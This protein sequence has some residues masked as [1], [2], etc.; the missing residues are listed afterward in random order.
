LSLVR[1]WSVI[2][3]QFRVILR[4]YAVILSEAKDL[5]FRSEESKCRFFAS[6]RMTRVALIVKDKGV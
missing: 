3:S 1:S 4:P 5:Q 2:L 6:L